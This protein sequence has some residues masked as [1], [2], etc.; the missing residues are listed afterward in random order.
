M[1]LFVISNTRCQEFFSNIFFR[2]QESSVL[3]GYLG[4][5]TLSKN[6]NHEIH[7]ADAYRHKDVSKAT[8]E[9][10]RQLFAIGHSPSSAWDSL[11]AD[12][13]ESCTHDEYIRKSADQATCPDISYCFRQVV[14]L[15]QS[16]VQCQ[17]SLFVVQH[18][19]HSSWAYS[20]LGT[21]HTQTRLY[22]YVYYANMYALPHRNHMLSTN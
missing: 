20:Q 1:L 5:C 9:K 13:F 17:T 16:V 8:N 19:L 15:S 14:I 21:E 12:L 18:I 6:H 22:L 2:K 7:C 4:I 3:E 10:L 11:Q